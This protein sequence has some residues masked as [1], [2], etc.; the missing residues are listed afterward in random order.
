MKKF[1][2]GLD[3]IIAKKEYNFEQFKQYMTCFD[4]SISFIYTALYDNLQGTSDKNKIV[5]KKIYQLLQEKFGFKKMTD[6]EIIDFYEN[7]PNAVEKYIRNAATSKS[8][9][10]HIIEIYGKPLKKEFEKIP[11][12]SSVKKE[13]IVYLCPVGRCFQ[14]TDKEKYEGDYTIKYPFDKSNK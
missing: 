3:D 14:S 9:M 13:A 10:H 2:D 12:N 8:E 6:D 1:K 4:D 11:N 5:G 7:Y